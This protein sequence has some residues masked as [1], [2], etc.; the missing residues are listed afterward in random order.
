MDQ[1]MVDTNEIEQLR[2][3]IKLAYKL[4]DEM[5]EERSAAQDEIE[6]LRAEIEARTLAFEAAIREVERLRKQCEGLAQSAMNNGQD[7]LLKEAEI[8][9]LRELLQ[10][11]V[12]SLADGAVEIERLRR[13]LAHHKP[14]PTT[15]INGD[16]TPWRNEWRPRL[17]VE[18]G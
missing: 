3:E 5:A 8:E 14:C 17:T 10:T 1:P 13:Q 11:H 2:H 6:R 15:W 9:R 12:I 18:R 7:L 4:I 16:T